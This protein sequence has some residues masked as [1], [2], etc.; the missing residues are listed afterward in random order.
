[1][2]HCSRDTPKLTPEEIRDGLKSRPMWVLT[3]EGTTISRAFVAKNWQ[4]AIKFLNAVSEVAEAKNHHPDVHLTGYRNVQ[5]DLQTH[6]IGG[7]SE[8]D[9]NMASELDEIEVDYSPKWLKEYEA[10]GVSQ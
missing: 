7:V 1:M 8:V 2:A 3:N 6:V 9:M 10:K 4:A 5:V